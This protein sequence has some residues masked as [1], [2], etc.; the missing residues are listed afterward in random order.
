MTSKQDINN[1]KIGLANLEDNDE[2]MK[3]QDQGTAGDQP[4][5][6]E[7]ER[8]DQNQELLVHQDQQIV[9]NPAV[10]TDEQVDPA[11]EHNVNQA[12]EP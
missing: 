3:V 7:A 11:A 2:E 8:S 9:P 4:F 10:P 1:F 12:N 5:P 6:E